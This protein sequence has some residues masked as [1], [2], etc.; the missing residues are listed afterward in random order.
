MKVLPHLDAPISQAEFAL[1][2]GVSEARVSQLVSD[3]VLIK[4]E[5]ARQW[6]AAY[7]ERLRGQAAARTGQG[8][9][10]LVLERALLTRSQR[11]A[12]DLKNA[13][14][15][16]E[17]A[18]VG[19]LADVL[20]AASSAVVDRMDQVEG[21]LR[22]ACPHLPVEAVS[23]VKRVMGDV[24]NEWIR[25]TAKLVS[26]HVDALAQAEDGDDLESDIREGE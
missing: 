5:S 17:F 18:P 11:E 14:N 10:D 15:R 3:G 16:K 13:V 19:I 26:D 20:G 2:V 9:A 21:Q 1:I 24:R 25:V 6:L 8:G 4:G 23:T 7:C 12:Q 22:K